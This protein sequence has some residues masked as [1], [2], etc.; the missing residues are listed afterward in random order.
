MVLNHAAELPVRAVHGQDV[1]NLTPKALGV[2]A[3]DSHDYA[4]KAQHILQIDQRRGHAGRVR[5]GEELCEQRRLA[6]PARSEK[7]HRDT[8][9]RSTAVRRGDLG[10]SG[11]VTGQ[12]VLSERPGHEREVVLVV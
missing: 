8:S 3:L 11:S 12:G 7:P 4:A 9:P 10:A 5:V 2:G 6:V 1:L